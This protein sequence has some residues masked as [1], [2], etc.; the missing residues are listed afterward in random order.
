MVATSPEVAPIRVAAL[1]A[2]AP[3]PGA[4]GLR[5]P[6]SYRPP[7]ANVSPTKP[8]GLMKASAA[9]VHNAALLTASNT[10][11]WRAMCKPT[12]AGL[13]GIDSIRA[14]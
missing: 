10:A 3:R 9:Q 14:S 12:K 6:T 4:E 2:R 13:E 11:D 7:G 1:D 5:I 8:Q